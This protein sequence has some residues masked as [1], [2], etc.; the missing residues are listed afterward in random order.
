M[1]TLHECYSNYCVM[2]RLCMGW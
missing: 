2:T 1:L